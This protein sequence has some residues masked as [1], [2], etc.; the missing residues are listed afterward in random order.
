MFY[1][2]TIQP[3]EAPELTT[4]HDDSEVSGEE[5]TFTWECSPGAYNYELE[6][7]YDED[8]TPLF[9]DGSSFITEDSFI[10]VDGFPDGDVGTDFVWRVKAHNDGG[11]S[12]YSETYHFVNIDQK[13]TLYVPSGYPTIQEAIDVAQDGDIVLVEPGTYHENLIF[14]GRNITVVSTEGRDVTIID[15]DDD[16]RVVT[17]EN[18]E[19]ESCVL[20]GFTIKDG[21]SEY[22]GG[23]ACL[24][25]SPTLENLKIRHNVADSNNNGNWG[26]G[27]AFYSSSSCLRNSKICYNTAQGA[28]ATGGGICCGCSSN[29]TLTNVDIYNNNVTY[30]DA[31]G[32]GLCIYNSNVTLKKVAI[33]GN[34]MYTVDS[35]GGGIYTKG[36]YGLNVENVT[37]FDNQA[38]LG[39]GIYCEGTANVNIANSIIRNNSSCYY[40]QQICIAGGSIESIS[41]SDIED[42]EN[43]IYT[44]DAGNYNWLEGNIDEDPLFV[45]PNN[46]DLN[47][48]IDSPC[49]DTGNP[50]LDGDGITWVND[51]NDQDPDGTRMDMGALYFPKGF[52]EGYVTLSGGGDNARPVTDVVIQ[53]GDY[54]TNPD[55]NGYYS[56]EVR[57]GFYD[58]QAILP[59]YGIQNEEN[60]EVSI[61]NPTTIDFNLN[62]NGYI[63]VSQDDVAHFS[64]P[65]H[66]TEAALNNETVVIDEGY[67]VD[68]LFFFTMTSPFNITVRGASQAHPEN[69]VIYGSCLLLGIE[70]VNLDIKYLTFDGNNYIDAL[71]SSDFLESG[72]GTITLQGNIIK[73]YARHG[74]EIPDEC[75]YYF[76][77]K[78]NIIEDCNVDL[79]AQINGA[80]IY[81]G[82]SSLIK[83]N[84]IRNNTITYYGFDYCSY[85][86]GLYINISA[87]P[88]EHVIIENNQ[89]YGNSA[90]EGG[91]IFCTG[92]GEIEI[93][94][95]HIYEN[96]VSNLN[97][98]SGDCAGIYAEDCTN[99]LTISNNCLYN[100]IENYCSYVICLDHD[101]NALLEN[102]TIANNTDLVAIRAEGGTAMIKNNIITGNEGGI[103]QWGCNETIEYCNVVGNGTNYFNCSAGNGCIS[104]PPL[105]ADSTNSDYSLQWN[106]TNF[107]PCIDTG[108]PDEQYN[109]PDGTPADM[110]AIPAI[111]H[112]YFNNQYDGEVFDRIEWISFPALN[113]TTNGYMDALNVLERQELI[114]ENPQT[115][116]ILDHVL[117]EAWNKI[118]FA[119]NSWHNDLGYFDSR[120][121]YKFVLQEQYDDIPMKGISGTWEAESTPIQLFANK[122]NWVGC[123][124]QESASR[125]EAFES[126]SDEW[127]EIRSEHWA[128][129]RIPEEP[130]PHIRGTVNPGELYIIRVEND[131]QL[132][133]NNSGGGVEP[134]IREKTDYFTYEETVDYMPI[135]VDTVYSDTTVAEIAVYSDDQCIGASKVS[136]GYPV[137]IL[138]YTP[139]T[140]KN[141]NNGLEFMLLYEGQKRGS[142]KSI[143]YITYSK[144]AQAF[145]AQPLYYE[146]NAFSTVQLNTDEPSYTQQI[147]LMQNY[148]NPVRTNTTQINFMPEQK[149]QHTELNIY[150]LK[151]QLVRTIDCD[152]IISSGTKN[153]YY[154][155]TWD[156]RDSHGKDVRNG[157]YFYKLT[158]GEKRAVH[159]MLIMK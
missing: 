41:Y 153:G 106:T 122:E 143:P 64:Q 69:T 83:S 131:C 62:Y 74:I 57:A 121:G 114:D 71:F 137:Q 113:R 110:G 45:D 34:S 72:E 3:P 88:E 13:I 130:T 4:P 93:I 36:L 84:I 40:D 32:G 63:I 68:D 66:A 152:G 29:I 125:E 92:D 31:K 27:V 39:S 135:T 18:G 61:S 128:V 100:N 76:E 120:Q 9:P 155:L 50:D 142:S 5:I 21:T 86:G 87:D 109:D 11:S 96:T 159:K 53:A 102:N 8:F 46:N 81:C 118:Y 15:G 47:L 78:E 16:G 146:R 91:A 19:D 105:F 126:I 141:G 111:S 117:F 158:S 38:L 119:G 103:S 54:T 98:D 140:L 108:D 97:L 127:T 90:Y 56:L 20:S 104:E 24:D 52:L 148:P 7:A 42:G 77:I 151:G 14:R 157:I 70:E 49:I 94:D 48:S 37:I 156:C 116:D 35:Y 58:V 133:W 6:I 25:S 129:E 28:Y 124:L 89:I 1:N 44:I 132:I 149:A 145:I 123:Y 73:R 22:G 26:G 115:T 101:S 80:G 147:T 139:E 43:G 12:E 112:D 150:N 10:S 144:E 60:V 2:G 67:Y 138:A 75:S 107:S 51:P 154:S 79:Y 17:F 65:S 82:S 99:Q 33:Y 55:E 85:G 95:N 23:I 30:A 134:Y 136:D 59:G